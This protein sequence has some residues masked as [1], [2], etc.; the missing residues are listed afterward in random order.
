MRRP[1]SL[2]AIAL[3]ASLWSAALLAAPEPATPPSVSALVYAMGAM[4]CHQQPDRSFH[5]G[6]V[7]YPVCARCLGLYVGAVAGVIAWGL[8]GGLGFTPRARAAHFAHSRFK[9]TLLGVAIPTVLTVVTGALGVWDPQ[10]AVRAG[11]AFPLGAAI[12]AVV[13]AAAAGDLR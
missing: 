3:V 12:A 13:A 7:Q 9:P 1:V 10:N 4:V 11:L 8:V 6:D 2:A 5:R